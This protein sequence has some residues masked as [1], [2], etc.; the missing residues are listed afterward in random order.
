MYDKNQTDNEIILED[1]IR[2]KIRVN[3]KILDDKIIFKND[4]MPTYHFANVVDDLLMKISHVVRGEE[5]LPSLALHS[6]LYKSFNCSNCLI[7]SRSF[8]F[9]TLFIEVF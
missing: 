6:S 1:R 7:K 9:E 4:G 2:G 5:W 3:R 8:E